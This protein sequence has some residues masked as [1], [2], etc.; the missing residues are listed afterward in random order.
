[1]TKSSKLVIAVFSLFVFILAYLVY[2]QIPKVGYV[3]YSKVLS[4]FK[5]SKEVK[6]NEQIFH[7][8][9]SLDSLYK[10][11]DKA[12]EGTARVELVQRIVTQK[13]SLADLSDNYLSEE[14][15]KIHQRVRSYGGDFCKAKGYAVLMGLG[16]DMAV[17]SGDDSC[18]VTEEFITYL[19]SRYEGNN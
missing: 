4:E 7:G 13:N 10:I 18:D 15:Q 2:I 11:L 14:L 12:P 16:P 17:I 9:K 5:M 6:S 1:M 19:N 3:N 8:Q